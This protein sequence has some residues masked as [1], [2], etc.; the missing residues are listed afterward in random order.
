MEIREISVDEVSKAVASLCIK[1]NTELGDDVVEAFRS[2]RTREESS[3]GREILKLTV[4]N[5]R[6]AQEKRLPICQDTGLAVVFMDVGRN[7]HFSGG[8]LAEAVDQGVSD[9]YS[10][11]HLRASSLDAVTR[12]NTAD[13]TPAVL[14]VRIVPGSE[15]RLAVMTKGFGGENFSRIK[16]F[17]PAAGLDG[18]K[19]YVVETVR[20]AGSMPCPPV[21]V[22]VC[23]GG[24]FESA[25]IAA[26]RSLLR[27]LSEQSPDPELAAI[28]K[29]LLERINALGIGPQGLGG[30]TTALAVHVVK[31]HTH[32]GSLPVAVNLQCHCHRHAETTL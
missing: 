17:P 11:A 9:G 8:E 29:E 13:N 3:I 31:E 25:A 10:R 16:L 6:I 32:I 22:G 24:T 4:E 26:K 1:A 19:N 28:E 2:A 23:L 14:H 20:S 7:V 12:E 15:V 21:I 27:P 30:K 5:A 18:A